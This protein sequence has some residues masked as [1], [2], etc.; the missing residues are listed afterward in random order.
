VVFFLSTR[1][2]VLSYSL[3]FVLSA[4]KVT[5][6][7]AIQLIFIYHV[8]HKEKTYTLPVLCMRNKNKI[9]ISLNFQWYQIV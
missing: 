4:L 6:S 9:Q 7:L 2:L 1:S 5:F 3:Y 8:P